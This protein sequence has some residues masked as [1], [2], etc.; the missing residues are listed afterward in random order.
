M[1][2]E[3]V[4]DRILAANK[5]SP[6]LEALRA[7]ARRADPRN[8]TDFTL[9]DNL[10]LYQERLVVPE[11]QNLRTDLIREAHTQVSTAH[12]GQDKTYQLL[13]PRYYWRGMK[14]SIDRYVRNCHEC[15]RATPPRDKTPG[16][17]Q[18]LP[19]LDRSW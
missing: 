10:L 4:T 14:S 2:S 16:L 19:V 9:E 17:L 1:E 11:D 12:P 13:R 7:E 18:P 6:S 5:E 15:R 3:S 8:P